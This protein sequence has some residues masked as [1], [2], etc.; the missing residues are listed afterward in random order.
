MT[1]HTSEF[2]SSFRTFTSP[3]NF[4][5]DIFVPREEVPAAVLAKEAT[6]SGWDS[7]NCIKIEIVN[8]VLKKSKSYPEY[9]KISMD[10]ETGWEI[11]AKFGPWQIAPGGTGAILMMKLPLTSSKMTYGVGE[12]D[13]RNGYALISIKLRYIP[14]A[15]VK[16]AT[17]TENSLTIED[18]IADAQ[19]R[20]PDDPAVTIQKINYGS[21][22]PTEEQAALY[23]ASF[24][25]LLN[26]NL[27]AFQ[28]VFAVVNLNQAAA[29]EEFQW[30]KP[31]YT[32]YAYFQGMDV[33]GSYFAIL[34][35]VSG[36]SPE[37]L[38][39][40]V[41]SSAIPSG[42]NASILLSNR[43]FLERMVLPGL[44]RA[45]TNAA[46]GDFTIPTTNDVIECNS[47]VDLDP[48]KV[49]ATNYTPKMNYFRLQIVGDEVQIH[50]KVSIHISPGI[51]AYINSTYYYVLGLV[52]KPDGSQTLD[53]EQSS[54]PD[55]TSWHE[56]ASW[57]TY[58]ELVVALIGAV[59]GAVVGE[60]IKEVTKKIIVVVIITVVAGV[61]AAIP[62]MI[63]D[64]AANGAAE[65]LPPIGPMIDDAQSPVNWPESS[66]F[67][68]LTA[69]LNGSLQ[70]GGLLEQPPS[71]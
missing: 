61:L 14:Q 31:T 64:I 13:I 15:S 37:G 33:A 1:A 50:T 18:L 52:D 5:P 2:K 17:A 44:T 46:S 34:N 3:V 49:A 57:V 54:A 47:E 63:A 8:D 24:A 41:S 38:T 22:N 68:L 19:A 4:C 30:L 32:S 40:Q 27:A 10:A 20:S 70:F 23:H 36:H 25:Y 56:V 35:Q 45:F 60:S 26:Q 12:L 43:L 7:V 51:D 9:L 48:V 58:T 69:E 66:G 29:K 39:N 55:I 67:E 16:G 62:A 65:A 71:S 59:I 53:F 28:H 11:D 42:A 6:T 21:A